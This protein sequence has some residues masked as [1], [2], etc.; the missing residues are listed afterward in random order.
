MPERSDTPGEDA[1]AA[2]QAE[3][4]RR[5]LA[6]EAG[7]ATAA[8]GPAAPAAGGAGSAGGASGAAGAAAGA[9]EGRLRLDK[10]GALL[11]VEKLKPV[12]AH[13]RADVGAGPAPAAAA[14]AA[15]ARAAAPREPGSREASRPGAPR[16]AVL[17][18]RIGTFVPPGFPG[19]AGDDEVAI[20]AGTFLYGEERRPCSV[21]AFR[22]DRRPVTHA[23][24]ERFVQATGHRA[25]LYWPA[26]RL[27][28]DLREHPVV[29][30]DYFDA[31]AYARWQGKDLPFEDEWERAARGTDGRDFPWGDTPEPGRTNTARDGLKMTVPVGLHPEN[32]S[33][34]GMRDVLGNAW[35][36][37]HSP[38]A[39]GGIVVRGGSWFDMA[40]TA[41][42][43]F[44]FA[45][46]PSARNG[47]IG[48]RCVRRE[49][50]RPAMAREVPEERIEAEVA[51]RRGPQAPVD[52][53]AFSAE[54]RD[55][56]PDWRR[57]RALLSERQVTEAVTAS[58]RSTPAP[59]PA[60]APA[61]PPAAV[62][63]PV[64]ATG[65]A[66]PPAP[67][68]PAA[69]AERVHVSSPT[70][71]TPLPAAAAAAAPAPA[72]AAS[73]ASAASVPA[74]P[75]AA[76]PAPAATAAAGTPPALW[77]LLVLGFALVA[78]LL[79]WL[80]APGAGAPAGGSGGG[81]SGGVGGG[82]AG[83]QPPLRAG[84]GPEDVLAREPAPGAGARDGQPVEVLEGGSAAWDQ[85]LAR[86]TRL[87][88]FAGGEEEVAAATRAAARS[89]HRRYPAERLRVVL[90]LPRT[91]LER[92]DGTLGEPAQ[93]ERALAALGVADG[94]TVVLDP[95][96]A[97]R[98]L[99]REVRYG[100]SEPNAALLLVEG[101]KVHQT[102]PPT[103]P[104]DLVRLLPLVQRVPALVRPR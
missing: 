42:A 20:A 81:T 71:R 22:I 4:L 46:R 25:P 96:E 40:H 10:S 104:M 34:D 95:L 6:A 102:Q 15:P 94:M 27:P 36:M 54:R 51:A 2:R 29:G 68:A 84:R 1:A 16:K 70:L 9:G 74:A 92:A 60:A 77:V 43:W 49:A 32:E 52:A 85:L 66:A 64:P 14:P 93:L 53:S 90:V 50:P 101:I 45:A 28:D 98:A 19:A 3:A 62:P 89:L 26:G 97:R 76:A 7:E 67:A 73:A 30:V 41:K 47:T 63:A 44:R 18:P 17:P 69:A 100:L 23:D 87:V 13:P 31:L 82:E 88:V 12:L 35:Q 21:P 59:R 99:V 83:E 11:G 79:A 91:A 72:P 80:L 75:T 103:G 61:A 57:L 86:G 5:A 78:G 38:A 39:G 55:L 8:A 65:P 56:V 37:T 58:A 48:F 24:Y 33:P